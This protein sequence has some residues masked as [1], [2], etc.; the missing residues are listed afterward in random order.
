MGLAAVI[1]LEGRDTA[2]KGG[3]VRRLGWTLDPRSF[4][5]HPIAA[6][7]PHQKMQHYMQRFWQR[8][9]DQGQI[10]VFDRS[11]YGRVQVERIEGF[12][13][14]SEWKRAYREINEFERTLVDSAGSSPTRIFAIATA[15]RSTPRRLRI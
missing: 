5:V 2:G 8:L 12:A 11:W 15:G 7:T 10:V 9:P 1:V 3:V 13:C 6:P 14:K 4:K